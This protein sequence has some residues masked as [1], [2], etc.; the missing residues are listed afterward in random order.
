MKDDIKNR[1]STYYK[2]KIKKKASLVEINNFVS[3]KVNNGVTLME[4]KSILDLSY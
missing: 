4:G 3:E 1:I 2:T